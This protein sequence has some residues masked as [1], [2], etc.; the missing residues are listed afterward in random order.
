LDYVEFVSEHM[1]FAA[2]FLAS[3]RLVGR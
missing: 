1:P 2:K 3:E